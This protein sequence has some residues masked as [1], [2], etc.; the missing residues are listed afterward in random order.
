MSG[1]TTECNLNGQSECS[2]QTCSD[3]GP[4][5]EEFIPLKR[6]SSSHR[7]EEEEDN[8]EQQSRKS[9]NHRTDDD[10]NNNVQYSS[11]ESS[12]DGKNNSADKASKKQDW[13]RSAQLWNQS[14]AD[15]TPKEVISLSNKQPS[16]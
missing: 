13:L 16:P 6:A 4:V 7:E 5:L 8:D 2:E 14:S 11:D 10:D 12:K 9:T 3:E 1:T 15:P